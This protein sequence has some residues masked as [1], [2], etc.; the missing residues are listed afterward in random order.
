[1]R[2]KEVERERG[3][4]MRG[5][6]EAVTLHRGWQGGVRSLGRVR[7]EASRS[8]HKPHTTMQAVA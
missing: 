4:G 8:E 5:E 7:S 3:R 6:G 2:G 1:M